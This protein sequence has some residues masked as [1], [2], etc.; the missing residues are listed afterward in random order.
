MTAVAK[1]TTL[2]LLTCR[3][4]KKL[5]GGRNQ[6]NEVTSAPNLEQRK[7]TW[8]SSGSDTCGRMY[9]DT[10]AFYFCT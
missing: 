5:S 3:V 7:L 6:I 1:I 4:R 10:R 2:L 8:S 9:E